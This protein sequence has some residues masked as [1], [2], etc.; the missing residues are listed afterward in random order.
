[1][2][3]KRYQVPEL[4]LLHSNYYSINPDASSDRLGQLQFNTI[5][6]NI[7]ALIYRGIFRC[8]P[9]GALAQLVERLHGM[10]EVRSS[11]LLCSTRDFESEAI[12]QSHSVAVFMIRYSWFKVFRFGKGRFLVYFSFKNFLY[13]V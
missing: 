4:D 6:F 8:F 3:W 5:S 11:T 13:G 2:N 1:M 10:Q 9:W 12:F 7:D